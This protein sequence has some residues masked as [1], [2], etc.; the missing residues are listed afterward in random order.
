MG[1]RSGRSSNRG[2]SCR[3]R[4]N[5]VEMGMGTRVWAGKLQFPGGSPGELGTGLPSTSLNKAS[6]PGAPSPLMG[7]GYGDL[8]ALPPSRSW[9]GVMFGEWLY[10]EHH[11]HPAPT[12][13]RQEADL[14]L[15]NLPPS[16]GKEVRRRDSGFSRGFCRETNYSPVTGSDSRPAF[17]NETR[18]LARICRGSTG[19]TCRSS[20]ASASPGSRLS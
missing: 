12:K 19:C 9:M 2:C 6:G 11:P 17:Q 8:A 16:R 5:P 15:R 14:S 1:W 3:R 13:A 20:T 10:A 4:H 7:E 18:T